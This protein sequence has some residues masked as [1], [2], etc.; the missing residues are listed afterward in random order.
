[1][2]IEEVINSWRSFIETRKTGRFCFQSMTGA[3]LCFFYICRLCF[4][5]GGGRRLCHAKEWGILPYGGRANACGV[6]ESGH[7][8]GTLYA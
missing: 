4:C 7:R 5:N 1:M 6:R 8:E 2:K 3:A